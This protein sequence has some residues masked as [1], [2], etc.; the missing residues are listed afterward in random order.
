ML[1]HTILLRSGSDGQ[2]SSDV[3]VSHRTAMPTHNPS[4]IRVGRSILLRRAYTY[5]LPAKRVEYQQSP[6]RP[7]LAESSSR[8]ACRESSSEDTQTGEGANKA[9]SCQ[10]S[11]SIKSASLPPRAADCRGSIGLRG[12]KRRTKRDK[13]TGYAESGKSHQSSAWGRETQSY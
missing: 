10:K 4:Q 13:K 3:H 9:G 7:T 1:T 11:P 6:N 12:C 8:S 2:Y 5:I